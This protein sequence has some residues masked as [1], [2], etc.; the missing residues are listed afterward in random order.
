MRRTVLQ[1][2]TTLLLVVAGFAPV[3]AAEFTDP[4]KREIEQIV[5]EYLLANPSVLMEVS[6]AL[7]KKQEAEQA[8][9][10]S[11]GL[12]GNAERIL[13]SPADYVAGNPKGDVTIVEFFDYNCPYCKRAVPV[14][15]AL[16]AKDKKIRLVMKEF[17]ILG[18]ESHFASRAAVASISQGKYWQFHTAMMA[19]EGRVNNASVMS[20]AKD[21]GLDTAK[22]EADM[23]GAAVEAIINSTYEL[24]NKLA[25]NGTPA[26]IVGDKLIPGAV[27]LSQL[28]LEVARVRQSGCAIC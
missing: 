14:I 7:Q 3:S 17:P 26:F 28:E 9:K 20:L 10:A 13:R 11:A 19:N 5:R 2:V 6:D 23:K 1:F 4:Q 16:L 25:I 18:N 21:V 24:A 22:L 12:I 15:D 27:E 8:A